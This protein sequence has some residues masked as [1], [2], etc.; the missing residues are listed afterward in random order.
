M[1]N[2]PY[3]NA[4]CIGS[5]PMSAYANAHT[6]RLENMFVFVCVCWY[7]EHT[8]RLLPFYSCVYG[9]PDRNSGDKLQNK[10]TSSDI[11]CIPITEPF[12]QLTNTLDFISQTRVQFLWTA[13]QG[14]ME[15]HTVQPCRRD[16]LQN[17]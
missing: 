13:G 1:T 9:Y 16:R 11:A 8:V 14:Q 12:C 4:E 17:P 15:V 2:V 7:T 3:A 5:T 6:A 10:T